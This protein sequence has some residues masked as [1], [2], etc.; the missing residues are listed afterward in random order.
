MDA[1]N[2]FSTLATLHRAFSY[3]PGELKLSKGRLSFTAHGQGEFWMFQLRSLERDTHQS[4]LAQKLANGETVT[5]FDAPLR[6]LTVTVNRLG[7]MQ[8]AVGDLNCKIG[9]Y[10]MALL[11]KMPKLSNSPLGAVTGLVK[12]LI[13]L[14]KTLSESSAALKRARVWKAL[15]IKK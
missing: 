7:V 3:L 14:P 2:E 8:L 12:A 11:K 13:V 5:V 1:S 4:G 9:F 6:E 15:L 10:D